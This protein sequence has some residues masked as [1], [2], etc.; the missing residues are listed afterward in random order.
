M[1]FS[2]ESYL[3]WN[4]ID[5]YTYQGYF[6]SHK[7]SRKNAIEISIVEEEKTDFDMENQKRKVSFFRIILDSSR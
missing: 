7:K 4:C 5:V 3:G 2:F 6:P 1:L